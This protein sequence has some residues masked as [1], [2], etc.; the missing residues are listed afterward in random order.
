MKTE[1][2][3]MST[4]DLLQFSLLRDTATVMERELAHRLGV[5]VE[6]VDD[7]GIDFDEALG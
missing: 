1:Y 7:L 4:R 3:W 2:S 6:L 5:A